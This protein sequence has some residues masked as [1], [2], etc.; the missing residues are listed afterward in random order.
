MAED[1]PFAA[2]LE[3]ALRAHVRGDVFLYSRQQESIAADGQLVE[4]FTRIF[5]ISARVVVIVHREGWG[6]TQYTALERDAIRGRRLRHGVRGILVVS[7]DGTFPDAWYP[8]DEFR[9][10][11]SQF[12]IGQIA[13]II[14]Q[15]VHE[16]GGRL[17]PEPPLDKAARL[18]RERT[19]AS[20]LEAELRD[21]G[22][23]MLEEESKRVFLALRDSSGA[24]SEVSEDRMTFAE[25]ERRCVVNHRWA[26]LKVTWVRQYS[27]S[28]D[29]SSLRLE[30]FDTPIHLTGTPIAPPRSIRRVCLHLAHPE[31]EVWGWTPDAARSAGLPPFMTSSEVADWAAST[32]LDITDGERPS[33]RPPGPGRR[34]PSW[35]DEWRFR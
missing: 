34:G 1:E 15:R 12:E 27:N 20:A 17:G 10:S 33:R 3:S 9:L 23:H 21:H 22:A 16:E 7:L 11:P 28:L 13:A 25:D 26:G 24:I 31:H 6:T 19:R 32:L 30:F 35:V 29:G 5:K 14:A 2:Q 18:Q 8:E 4:L